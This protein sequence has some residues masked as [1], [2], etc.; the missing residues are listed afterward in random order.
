[1]AGGGA[2]SARDGQ[3]G[4]RGGLVARATPSALL[5]RIVARQSV[6]LIDRAIMVSSSLRRSRRRAQPRGWR[7]CGLP[8]SS[9]EATTPSLP[10]YLGRTRGVRRRPWWCG[11]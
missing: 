4:A 10:V 8:A 5:L 11:A 7:G 9:S 2:V 3:R 1:M 6:G